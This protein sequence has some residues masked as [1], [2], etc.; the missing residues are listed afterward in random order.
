M[1][2]R[3]QKGYREKNLHFKDGRVK[4]FGE[5]LNA[6]KVIK[7]YAWEQSFRNKI[8]DIRKKELDVMLKMVN[9]NAIMGL[10][11]DMAPFLVTLTTFVAFVVSDRTNQMTA[12]DAFVSL[13][14][15]N[16]LRSP[17][18]TFATMIVTTIQSFVSVERINQ[19]LVGEDL[20][21]DCV[22]HDSASEH[23]I[24][25][26]NGTFAWTRDTKPCL[27]NINLHVGKGKLIAVVGPVGCGKSSLI[28]AMLGEME[29]MRGTVSTRGSIAYVPQQAWI[30]NAT[31]RDNVQFGKPY[32]RTKYT[33]V[34]KHCQLERDLELLPAGD[35]TE[36]GEKGINLSGGQKQRVSLA[37][38]MYSENDV[39]LLDDPLSAV[40]SHV[41]KA[42]FKNVI[43]PEGLLKDKTRILV[44]HGV[45]WLPMV[46]EI[47]VMQDGKISERGSYDYLVSNNGPFAQSLKTFLTEVADDPVEDPEMAAIEKNMLEQLDSVETSKGSSHDDLS[48]SF[49]SGRPR[50]RKRQIKEASHSM[51]IMSSNTSMRIREANREAGKL[52]AIETVETG[53]VKAKVFWQYIT[54]AGLPYLG[55]AFLFYASF[56]AAAVSS[57]FWLR[58]WTSDPDLANISSP[59]FNDDNDYYLMVYGLY[60]ASQAIFL[61]AFNWIYWRRMVYAAQEMHSKLANRLLRYPMNFFDTTPIGRILN[62]VSR[63]VDTVDS[64]LPVH[65]KGVLVHSSTVLV[66][67]IVIMSVSPITGAVLFPVI[68]VYYFCQKFFVPTSRQLKRIESVTRTPL[69]VLLFETLTGASSVRAY[70][71]TDRFREQAKNIVDHNQVFFFATH[72]SVRWLQWNLDFL[73]SLVIFSAGLFEIISSSSSEVDAGNAGLS[74]S[75]ALQLSGTLIWMTRE[76]T[77]FETHIVSV[78]RLKEYSELPTEADWIIPSQRPPTG[79][80][81][82]GEVCFQDYK[83]RYREGLDLVLK[84]IGFTIK[85][86]EKVG[87]VGRTGAGKTS[88]TLS[89]FRLIEAV[90][91]SIIIDGVDIS[92]I[93]LH[94][95]RSHLTIL[96]QEPV[97]FS[98]S[99]RFNLDPFDEYPDVQLWTALERAHLRGALDD[100]SEGLDFDCGEEGSN[101]SVG[102]R[103]LVCLARALLRKTTILVLDEATAAVDMETD[104]LIQTT[105]RTAFNNCTV[106]TIAHRLNTIMDYDRILVMD[107]GEVREF[108]APKA[109]LSDK[110]SIFYS[111]AKDAGII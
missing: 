48:S 36:I 58:T 85:P 89:L 63:D 41:G 2:A 18:N 7:L 99:L 55:M 74:V 43:G 75:Y 101:L 19:F 70:G 110:H 21:S 65:V 103:Q 38:A 26:T 82:Q 37:R 68:L 1:L 16:I 92:S 40:D 39:Y 59:N 97:L 54:S 100:I 3:M 12:A 104:T 102:Q 66:T 72:A 42:L 106:I 15:F 22:S 64:T 25:I 53:K 108:D 60:G 52:V 24:S 11:W 105:I 81:Q 80:P 4:L 93:G 49:S 45:H 96:P 30:Q 98:G 61:V 14:Y 34:I 88:L 62:R 29:K 90:G 87:V 79:W 76:A 84:G 8:W 94:D 78:E 71:A 46:D 51:S 6:V 50:R 17:L 77:E 31:V 47:I 95:L 73:S 23:V 69:Y 5:I 83:T 86:G 67:I 57:S 35:M 9:V 109:L 44:T 10:V 111:M 56:Q 20:D 107:A 33:S 91:G 27:S 13:A 32:I 28:N